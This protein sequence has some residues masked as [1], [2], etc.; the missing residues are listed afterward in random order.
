MN[1]I[2]NQIDATIMTVLKYTGTSII[3][4]DRSLRLGA[5]N[6]FFF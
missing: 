3:T 5:Q 6:S 1:N 2:D 4:G